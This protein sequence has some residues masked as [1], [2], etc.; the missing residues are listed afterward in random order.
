[1]ESS[2]GTRSPEELVQLLA[3][4]ALF[5][6]V[7][8][9]A[10]DGIKSQL[11]WVTLEDGEDLFRDG[12]VVDALY[13]V[14]DG[15]LEVTKAKENRDGDPTNDRLVLARLAPPATIGEMQI[16]M[17]GLRSAT[18]TASLPSGL[19]KFPKPAFDQLLAQDQRIVEELTKT[20]MPPS[21][22]P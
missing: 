1:M 20:I 6:D 22:S 18:V 3:E 7:D 17:G 14:A 2:L 16:L 5:R 13:V 11:E 12:D 19:V 4:T 10:L 21:P 15:W 8:R 9:T